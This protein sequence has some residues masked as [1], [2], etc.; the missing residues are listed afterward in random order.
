M[1]VGTIAAKESFVVTMAG[2]VSVGPL[3]MME[4][5]AMGTDANRRDWQFSMIMP[6]GA[7]QK[8]KGIQKFCNDCHSAAGAED[9]H[10]MFLPDEFRV[11]KK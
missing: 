8:T 11:T 10:L 6:N 9:D 1:P 3:F 5:Q 2:R 4:K 7:V